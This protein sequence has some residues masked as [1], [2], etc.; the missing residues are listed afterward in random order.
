MS[1]HKKSISLELNTNEKSLLLKRVA[2]FSRLSVDHLLEIAKIA[3]VLSFDTRATIFEQGYPKEHLFVV[4]DGQVLKQEG[5]QP[6]L[7]LGSGHVFEDSALVDR[8]PHKTKALATRPT[9]LLSISRKDFNE[10]LKEN[11]ELSDQITKIMLDA[12]RLQMG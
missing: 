7:L 5:D 3:K 12:V 2:L 4:I 10:L 8:L 11:K 9:R 1:T 6:V